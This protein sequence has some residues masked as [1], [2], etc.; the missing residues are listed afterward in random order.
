MASQTTPAS[1]KKSVQL[2]LIW[3]ESP[4]CQ[5][6]LIYFQNWFVSG[7]GFNTQALISL[8]GNGENSVIDPLLNFPSYVLMEDLQL[9][10]NPSIV[11]KVLKEI[12]LSPNLRDNT[13][14][15]IQ[16][17]EANQVLATLLSLD[18][19]IS[20]S[21][22]LVIIPITV[23][24]ITNE[25][26][27]QFFYTPCECAFASEFYKAQNSLLETQGAD[28]LYDWINNTEFSPIEEDIFVF[29]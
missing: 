16:G 6:Q 21:I 13:K 12:L 25:M 1:A 28:G 9:E 17:L 27:K 18:E 20:A 14:L 29:S 3:D 24:Q 23:D 19:E 4:F 26:G 5:E 7:F 10:P 15:F 8:H 11:L 2:A 22:N